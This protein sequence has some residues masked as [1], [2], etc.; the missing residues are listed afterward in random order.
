MR[1]WVNDA[2]ID[3]KIAIVYRAIVCAALML[4]GLAGSA[5]ADPVDDYIRRAM[6]AAHVPAA[7]VV[8]VR[9]G[10]PPKVAAYGIAD[11]EGG[12]P[13]TPDTAFQLASA[14]KLF[15]GILTLRSNCNQVRR[16]RTGTAELCAT[17]RSDS[18]EKLK[19]IVTDKFAEKG[20]PASQ[21]V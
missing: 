13:A 5:K 18:D 21:A 3:A 10:H 16:L 8:V 6:T 1:R 14:T 12:V 7:A 2:R 17:Y 19:I 9:A 15:T 11:I 4:L 20:L